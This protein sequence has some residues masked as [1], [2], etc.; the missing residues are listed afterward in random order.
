MLLSLAQSSSSHS[1]TE[2]DE[3]LSVQTLPQPANTK[4]HKSTKPKGYTPQTQWINY[5]TT[6]TTYKSDKLTLRSVR[7][8]VANE[9][10]RR[11][12][13]QQVLTAFH[14]ANP[15]TIRPYESSKDVSAAVAVAA[16]APLNN[17]LNIIEIDPF[18]EYP[19]SM[20]HRNH[21]LLRNLYSDSIICFTDLRDGGLFSRITEPA[22]FTAMLSMSS[23]HLSTETSLDKTVPLKLSISA[24]KSLNNMLTSSHVNISDDAVLCLIVF[25]WYEILKFDMK[26]YKIHV[27]GLITLVKMKGG[28]ETLKHNQLLYGYTQM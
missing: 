7:Q 17:R 15:K 10:S 27:N 9:S 18:R 19:I 3:T 5:S 13:A 23:Y 28:I 11:R 6:S 24:I 26:A 22:A 12:K 21:R 25:C 8:H 2:E 1:S 4:S 16:A 14:Q 20:N